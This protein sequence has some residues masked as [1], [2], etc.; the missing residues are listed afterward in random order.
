MEKRIKNRIRG[1]VGKEYS[2]DRREDMFLYS[3]DAMNRRYLPD[4]VA[5]PSTAHEVSGLIRLANEERFPIVPR[6]AGTGLT[7]G[8]LA[9][10]GGLIITTSRMNRI[11]EIDRDNLTAWVEPGVFNGELQSAAA[12]YGLFFP[13]DPAS[14]EFSTLGGN[15]AENA[16]GAR[17]VKYGVTRDYVMALEVVMPTGEIVHTGSASIK[18][19]TGYDLTRL[20]VG[21]E[22]TLGFITRLLLKL[23]PV[24]EAIGTMLVA[25]PEIGTAAKAVAGIMSS[26]VTPSTLEFMDRTAIECVKEHL[27]DDISSDVAALLL[28]EVDGSPSIVEEDSKL[29]ESE[30]LQA[31]ALY[32]K[33]ARK[34]EER[35][36][37]W[38][39]RRA[40]SPA[41]MK[42]RPLKINEDVAVPRMKI[43]DLIS[44]VEE[45]ARRYRVTIVNFG[46]AGDGNVHVNF[47]LDPEDKDEVSRAH[48]AVKEL[49]KLV[50]SL[51][52][53]LS[54][55]HGIGIA[56]APYLDIE[57]ES[58]AVEVMRK[59][60][61]ALD[62]NNILNPHKT[63]DYD[64]ASLKREL[65]PDHG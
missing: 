28:V 59:I 48:E 65:V 10:E 3:Y 41:I 36:S 11:L 6:G 2:S 54:G 32:F 47:L 25:F 23:I 44:G 9:V 18:S 20:I 27:K 13:P 19:V 45:L 42:I 31:G 8:A 5:H 51:G 17:A 50:V 64:V 26:R 29:L 35:E 61:Q 46:H 58:T 52:G 21:S 22:G 16:G 56:K 12:E 33:S 37:L 4:M 63:F 24:P 39:A 30:C 60:K 55:E 14:M 1:I 40:L 7:G 49:F 53:T 43:P 15:A 57:L 34:P 38:K 62:P